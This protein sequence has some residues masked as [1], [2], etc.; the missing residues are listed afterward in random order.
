M[1]ELLVIFVMAFENTK[2]FKIHTKSCVLKNSNGICNTQHSNTT[3]T[4]FLI[5]DNIF[6][7]NDY[8]DIL[9]LI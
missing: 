6:E 2:G 5:S 3:G 4:N 7:S 9:N 1:V 8:I